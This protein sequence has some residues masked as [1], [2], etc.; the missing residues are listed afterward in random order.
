[1]RGLGIA[2][3][4]QNRPRS[5]KLRQGNR[6][7]P[8]IGIRD[9][10]VLGLIR[11]RHGNPGLFTDRALPKPIRDGMEPS[12]HI[13]VVPASD[14]ERDPALD[15]ATKVRPARRP[16]FEA[17]AVTLATPAEGDTVKLG[18]IVQMQKTRNAKHGPLNLDPPLYQPPLLRQADHRQR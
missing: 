7:P 14:L 8:Q 9:R 17:D 18:A 6:R 16:L 1:M 10:Q 5:F 13:E 12:V 15:V 4:G 11:R 2:L 3:G